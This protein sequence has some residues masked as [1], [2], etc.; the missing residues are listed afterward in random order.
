[1]QEILF[2]SDAVL[3]KYESESKIFEYEWQPRLTELS[4]E[5]YR[6]AML[7][8]M[9]HVQALQPRLVVAN[10][11]HS[12]FAIRVDLQK[13]VAEN[14]IGPAVRLGMKKLALVVSSDLVIQLS[15]E[16]SLDETAEKTFETKYFD[17]VAAAYQWLA[18]FVGKY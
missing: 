11:K 17:E 5:E 1:M 16:Q 9:R 10:T 12:S 7:E 3:V 13:W 15:V 6:G 8:V 18:G 2:E 4:D 14:V